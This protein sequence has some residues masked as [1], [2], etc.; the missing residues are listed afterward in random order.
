[1][2]VYA[3]ESD[4]VC[5]DAVG[6]E[7]RWLLD[8]IAEDERRRRDREGSPAS[9]LAAERSGIGC[10]YCGDEDAPTVDEECS[11]AGDVAETVSFTG[12]PTDYAA[13]W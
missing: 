11:R 10:V 13:G 12:Y 5:G 7:A 1:V 2:I 6:L 4:A 8:M 3:C 9:C